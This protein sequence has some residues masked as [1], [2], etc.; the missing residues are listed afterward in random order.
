[1]TD[2]DLRQRIID[3]LEFEPSINAAHIGVVVDKGVVTLTGHVASY[4]EKLAAEYAVRRVKGVHGIAEEIEVR[5]PETK[6][7][8]DDEIAARAL[9]IIDWDTTIPD[10]KVQVKVQKGLVTLTG[11]VDWNFQRTAAADAVRK[12][13]GV[14]NVVNLIDVKSRIQVGD[15]KDR[16]ENALKRNAELEA[17]EIRILTIDSKVILDGRVHSWRERDAAERAA[18]SVP[19]VTAVDDRLTIS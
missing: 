9:Q 4:A 3:E 12:L 13:S 18:W 1:M 8:A 15:V 19:G 6:K 7:T 16:I 17:D 11:K 14:V 2:T 10:D 5:Y